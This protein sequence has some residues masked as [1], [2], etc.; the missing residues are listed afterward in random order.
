MFLA[1]FFFIWDYM[2][3]IHLTEIRTIGNDQS[4]FC[5]VTVNQFSAPLQSINRPQ[6][7]CISFSP[8]QRDAAAASSTHLSCPWSNRRAPRRKGSWAVWRTGLGFSSLSP[9]SRPDNRWCLRL[10]KKN[11][12][13]FSSS[14]WVGTFFGKHWDHPINS[15][16]SLKALFIYRD[17][18][19]LCPFLNWHL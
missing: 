11:I 13:Q 19:P 6:N 7:I 3:H 1:P 10:K 4:I 2:E 16:K 18:P 9:M 5:S 14:T 17:L 8:F 15:V 12:N